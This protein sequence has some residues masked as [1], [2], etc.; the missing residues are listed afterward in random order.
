MIALIKKLVQ[1]IRSFLRE[2]FHS[3]N[4]ELPYY[5][6]ILIAVIF[7]GVALK[8]FIEITDELGEN[9][10]GEFDSIITNWVISFRND[11]LTRYFKFMTEMG[12]RYAYV[13]I[14]VLLGA[15]FFFRLRNWKFVLQTVSVLL[16]ATLSNVLIKR[17]I[18]RARP[19]LEHMVSVNTLSFPSGHSMSA[20]AFYGFLIYL[21][22][23]MKMPTPIRI[24]LMI[25]LTIVVLS[26]GLSRIYLGVHFPSDVAAGFLGGLLWVTLCVI[27][28]NTVSLWRKRKMQ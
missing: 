27:I 21:C 2:R 20:M 19:T 6:A 12:D 24:G 25:L 1:W 14:S 28:F 11:G 7:F 9:E 4:P 10:L 5:I 15:Y 16:L 13:V 17:V 23:Q 3:Q 8:G 22:T 18:N 26:I